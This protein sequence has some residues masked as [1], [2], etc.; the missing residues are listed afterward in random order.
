MNLERI[1]QQ[2]QIDNSKTIRDAYEAARLKCE[3]I[4][5]KYVD[6]DRR[7]YESEYRECLKAVQDAWDV[8]MKDSARRMGQT[9]VPGERNS[10]AMM[11]AQTKFMTYLNDHPDFRHWY[12]VYRSY[13]HPTKRA[14]EFG[15]ALKTGPNLTWDEFA[16]MNGVQSILNNEFMEAQEILDIWYKAVQDATR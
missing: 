11:V 5:K 6:S 3:A 13:F 15:D 14:E 1:L 12:K 4:H 8:V 7:E 10:A 16:E 9:S 2:S